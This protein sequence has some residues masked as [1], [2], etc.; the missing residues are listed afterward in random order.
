MDADVKGAHVIGYMEADFHGNN[1]TTCRV[2]NSNTM[3]E[4][5]YWVDINTDN[6]NSWVVKPGV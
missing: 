3:R 2:T 1:L 5:L 6:S 4:R